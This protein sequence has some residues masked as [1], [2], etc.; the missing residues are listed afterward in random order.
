MAKYNIIGRARSAICREITDLIIDYV[1]GELD[2]DTTWE[3]EEHLRNCE[4]CTA[5]LNTYNKTIQMTR[6]LRYQTIP[7]EMK[8]RVRLFLQRRTKK[9]RRGR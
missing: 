1:L 3:F 8:R 5:F 4:D 9:R 6:S 7:P 2:P